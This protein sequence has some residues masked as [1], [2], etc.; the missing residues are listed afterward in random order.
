MA[1][2]QKKEKKMTHSIFKKLQIRIGKKEAEIRS[3]RHKHDPKGVECVNLVVW[4]DTFAGHF[5]VSANGAFRVKKKSH[6]FFAKSIFLTR[7]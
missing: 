7:T 6:S 2:G 1:N 3:N 4:N 5:F